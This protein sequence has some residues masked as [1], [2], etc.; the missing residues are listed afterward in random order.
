MTGDPAFDAPPDLHGGGV[1]R[2][3]FTDPP[4]ALVQFM[5]P[6]RGTQ[7]MAGWVIGPLYSKLRARFPEAT[8][9]TLVIDL[10]LMDGRDPAARAMLLERVSQGRGVIGRV[11]LVP[12]P[13]TSPVYLTTFHAAVTVLNSLGKEVRV[14][15]SLEKLIKDL[16]LKPVGA[17]PAAAV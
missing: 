2:A 9:L 4:G 7:E 8:M 6:S 1:L 16:G 14:E 13:K 12:P 15:S 10:T 11:G 5:R 3:W 17:L